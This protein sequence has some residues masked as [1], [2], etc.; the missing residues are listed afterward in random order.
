[1]SAIAARLRPR[2][3]AALASAAELA[4]TALRHV[5]R[6]LPGVVGP[7]LICYGLH[8]VWRPLGFI[9]AGLFLLALDRRMP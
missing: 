3:D 5:G 6:G 8:E 9:A 4:G 1:M 2:W 7:L